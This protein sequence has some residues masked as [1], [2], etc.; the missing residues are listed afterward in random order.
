MSHNALNQF[1]LFIDALIWVHILLRGTPI[2]K[3]PQHGAVATALCSSKLAF[4]LQIASVQRLNRSFCPVWFHPRLSICWALEAAKISCLLKS[5]PHSKVCSR[6]YACD[7]GFTWSKHDL[8]IAVSQLQK[9]GPAVSHALPELQPCLWWPLLLAQ[10]A[11]HA[12]PHAH[13]CLLHALFAT[14]G[15]KSIWS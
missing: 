11:T 6:L 2:S 13:T 8:N 15:A 9:R 7:I 1:G 10:N 5:L 3:S 14:W 12:V 4:T